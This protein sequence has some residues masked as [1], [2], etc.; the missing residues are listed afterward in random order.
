MALKLIWCF[1]WIRFH[2]EQ[3]GTKL[4]IFFFLIEIRSLESP[5]IIFDS[6]EGRAGNCTFSQLKQ[7]IRF[8]I[9]YNISGLPWVIMQSL[10]KVCC[11]A[12]W[13]DIFKSPCKSAWHSFKRNKT[14][15]K[16]P[17]FSLKTHMAMVAV[18]AYVGSPWKPFCHPSGLLSGVS[19]IC[20]LICWLFGLML[21]IKI[22]IKSQ[23]VFALFSSFPKSKCSSKDR[24]WY[25]WN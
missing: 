10:S 23:C 13:T 21:S 7:V 20:V 12:S 22:H 15:L 9:C 25:H 2:K 19:L 8:W 6:Y 24:P 5:P 1:I 11:K 4:L 18:F 14:R 17:V 3:C 16:A